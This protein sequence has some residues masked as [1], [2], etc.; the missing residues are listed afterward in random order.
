MRK[1][2]FFLFL[3]AFSFT[4]VQA[5]KKSLGKKHL[6]WGIRSGINLSTFNTKQS[7]DDITWRTGFVAGAFFRIHVAK[8]FSIQPE[9]LFSSM[10]AKTDNGV[11]E[12]T[13]DRVNY[14]SI[15]VLAK[16]NFARHF[17][18]VAGPQFDFLLQARAMSTSIGERTT[19]SY[20]D[21]SINGTAGIEFWPVH[22]LGVT[23]RYIHGF[24]DID[25]GAASIKN[26][27]VQITVAIKL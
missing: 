5:Q 1:I 23:A 24:T 3:T 7:N 16:Y 4:A 19:D 17:A 27:G 25:R 9:F 2:F 26:Q 6:D 8:S 12:T 18:V 20:E 21:H 13:T 14:F 15:P 10:G 22:A 11:T